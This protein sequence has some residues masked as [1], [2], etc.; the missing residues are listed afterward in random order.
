MD[1]YRVQ[2]VLTAVKE[3]VLKTQ[4]WS[5]S[6]Q[7]E[8]LGISLKECGTNSIMP[9]LEGNLKGPKKTQ[10]AQWSIIL[11]LNGMNTTALQHS[12]CFPEGSKK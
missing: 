10:A 6:D 7:Q 1:V 5:V 2:T 4:P 11:S 8:K 3:Q 12:F 9:N